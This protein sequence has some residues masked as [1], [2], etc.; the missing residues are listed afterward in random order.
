MLFLIS[1][2]SLQNGRALCLPKSINQLSRSKQSLCCLPRYLRGENNRSSRQQAN[3]NLFSRVSSRIVK[4]GL[5]QVPNLNIGDFCASSRV[6][7]G[8]HN[9][10]Y[11]F[12]CRRNCSIEQSVGEA[13]R[14]IVIAHFP[15]LTGS[16][17]TVLNFVMKF[18]RKSKEYSSRTYPQYLPFQAIFTTFLRVI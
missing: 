9:N 11:S 8:N 6:N 7:I 15:T 14:T 5:W 10:H 4:A 13:I 17:A 3:C 16:G 18:S 2:H 1:G 12:H